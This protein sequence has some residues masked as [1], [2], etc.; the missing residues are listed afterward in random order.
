MRYCRWPN[1]P[2]FVL[3]FTPRAPGVTLANV[4][5]GPLDEAGQYYEREK[6]SR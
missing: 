4:Y 2:L 1:R 6:V 5:V 3:L